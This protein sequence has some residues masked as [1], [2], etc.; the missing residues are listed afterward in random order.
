MGYWDD[1]RRVAAAHQE[2]IRADLDLARHTLR[3]SH[4]STREL[5][6]QVE[7]LERLLALAGR[8]TTVSEAAGQTLHDAMASVLANEPY[9]LRAGDLAAEIN[10]RKLYRMRDGR[11]VEPQQIHARAGNYSDLFVREGTFIKLKGG[12]V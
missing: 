11:A 2:E 12:K 10:R 3:R 5:E 7:V 4:E 1:V 9:G 6:R 8:E